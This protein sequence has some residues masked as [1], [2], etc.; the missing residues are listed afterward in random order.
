MPKT[1]KRFLQEVWTLC[2]AILSRPEGIPDD[3]VQAAKDVQA[4]TDKRFADLVDDEE[5][6]TSE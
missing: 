4:E 6:D 3:I 5:E 1:D 2:E